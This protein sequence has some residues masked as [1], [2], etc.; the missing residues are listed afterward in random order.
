MPGETVRR[1]VGL[2]AQD[3][4]LFDTTVAE[5]VR[6]ARPGAT[7]DDV[8]AALVR[9]G[10]GRWLA[11]R[12]EGL[13][14]RVGEHGTAVSGGEHRRI[15]LAR[16]LLADFPILILDEPDAHLD[17]PTADALLRDVLEAADGRSILLITHRAAFPG[18]HPILRHVDEVITLL[19]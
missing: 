12:P 5:N 13:A 3:A 17:E 8:L 2:C 9:A 18:D 6:L 7:D 15:V 14:T 4:H 11:E 1:I 16:A 10:L 19:G